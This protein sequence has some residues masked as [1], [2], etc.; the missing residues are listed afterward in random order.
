MHS[1]LYVGPCEEW[2]LKDCTTDNI[3]KQHASDIKDFKML[4]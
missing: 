3:Y 2:T 1:V 4:N